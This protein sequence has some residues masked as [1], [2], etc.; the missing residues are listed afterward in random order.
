[1]RFYVAVNS[2]GHLW[3]N[4]IGEAVITVTPDILFDAFSYALV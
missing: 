2:G 1:M 3:E 4:V